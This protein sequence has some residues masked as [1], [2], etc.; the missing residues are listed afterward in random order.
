MCPSHN[1][2]RVL[3]TPFTRWHSLVRPVDRD[4]FRIDPRVERSRSRASE[5]LAS[6]G[7]A[8]KSSEA[9]RQAR[10]GEAGSRAKPESR[11]KRIARHGRAKP[12]VGR[13]RKIER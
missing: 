7:E 9:N 13:S 8:G 6:E 11:A 3:D 5:P 2:L 10:A 4:T 1:L 12:E